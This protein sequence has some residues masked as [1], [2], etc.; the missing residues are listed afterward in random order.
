MQLRVARFVLSSGDPKNTLRAPTRSLVRSEDG[1]EWYAYVKEVPPRELVVEVVCALLGRVLDLPV[2]EPV[3]VLMPDGS[4]RF[5][6]TVIDAPPFAHFLNEDDAVI[7]RL[8]RWPN[9]GAA[10][11]FDEWIFNGDRHGGN[12]LHDGASRFWLIDHGEALPLGHKPDELCNPNVLFETAAEGAASNSTSHLLFL[13]LSAIM[14]SYEMVRVGLVRSGINN[15]LRG[16]LDD[17]L[18][19][20]ELRQLHLLRLIEQRDPHAQGSLLHGS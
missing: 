7:G 20:L 8:Q 18:E 4:V 3:I 11:C 2:S 6:S 10:A 14:A 12:L 15:V 16:D 17:I 5:G 9:T 19:L 13:R 1:Q